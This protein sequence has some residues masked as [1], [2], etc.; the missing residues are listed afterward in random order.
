MVELENRYKKICSMLNT[1][2]KLDVRFINQKGNAIFQLTNHLIPAVLDSHEHEYASINDTLANHSSNHYFHYQNSYG[3]EY[4][5]AG[6][7]E[8]DSYHACVLLGPFISSI[9]VMEFISDTITANKLPV[10]Q[11]KTLE[12]FY[13]SLSVI[14]SNEYRSIGE[15]LVQLCTHK[16]NKAQ[17]IT[18]EISP[19]PIN[20]EQVQANVD[21]SQDIIEF[22]YKH[23]KKLMNAISKGDTEAVD[24]YSKESVGLLDFSN[25]IPESPIRGTKNITLVLNTLCRVA[26]ERGGVH[27]IYIHTI[28][29]KYAIL[30]ERTPNLNQLKKLGLLMLEE[31]CEVV[32]RFSTRNYSP[33][34]KKAVDYIHFNLESPLTLQNIADNIHVNA[35]HLSRKFKQETDMTIT[36]YINHKR[37]EEAKLYLQRGNIPITDIAFMVGFNDLNYFSRVFKK[38][39]SLT[40]SEYIRKKRT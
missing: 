3:L 27:P 30:I 4:M 1:V 8:E 14:N 2:T 5:A 10:S 16:L 38:I 7:W 35:S 11:R 12:D 40:P 25:R 21:E 22:R 9:S 34:V 15:L 20:K 32:K 29:E 26:A 18:N 13:K 37:V 23:E 6:I 33:L 39:T 28:S 24:L 31:Y 36:D 17:L 19:P